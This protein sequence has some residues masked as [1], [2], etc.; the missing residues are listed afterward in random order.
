MCVCI[1]AS[2]KE[3]CIILGVPFFLTN[4]LHKIVL[5]KKKKTAL[6]IVYRI[7]IR[8]VFSVRNAALNKGAGVRAIALEFP[9]RHA[10]RSDIIEA[11]RES[12]PPSC[13]YSAVLFPARVIA[14]NERP[15][16]YTV[17]PQ[18]D[19]IRRAARKHRE[20]TMAR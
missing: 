19:A 3:L 10:P 20:S 17:V 15:R 14:K 16:G 2:H 13:F 5:A 11:A 4:R 6:Q 18:R 12:G 8:V 1:N 7:D 9:P